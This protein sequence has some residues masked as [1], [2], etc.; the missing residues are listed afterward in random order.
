MASPRVY[1]RKN[2]LQSGFM[3]L[4]LVVVMGLLAIVGSLGLFMSMD[5]LRGGAFRDE[6]DM[7][8]SS[9]QRARSQAI[10][11]ICLGSGCV[12]GQKHGVHIGSGEYVIFQGENYDAA[13]STNII[14]KSVSA[15][16]FATGTENTV[17][18]NLSGNLSVPTP[19]IITVFGL[20]RQASSTISINA[21]GRITWTN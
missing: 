8:V 20:S 7:V 3:V 4:E 9:L 15:A 16:V 1:I 11:N 18:N 14:I 6:R 19:A 21:E 10:N 17:F 13:T 12:E 5:S 2:R